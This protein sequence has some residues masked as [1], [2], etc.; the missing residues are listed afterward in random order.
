MNPS[1]RLLELLEV[2]LRDG[3]WVPLETYLANYP[4]ESKEAIYSRRSKTLWKDGIH[5]KF[6][7]GG[8]LWINLVAVNAWVA[9]SELRLAS[10]SDET[11]TESGSG[12]G[13]PSC[14]TAKSAANE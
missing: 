11:K 1:P 13:S 2:V 8:G 7:K 14:S 9:R 10:R 12:S 5:S 6:V 3:W 4:G